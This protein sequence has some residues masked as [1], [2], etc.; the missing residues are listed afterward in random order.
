[1]CDLKDVISLKTKTEKKLRYF[2]RMFD[3]RGVSA[4]LP[5][6]GPYVWEQHACLRMFVQIKF[7]FY[8]KNVGKSSF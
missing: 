2:I 7:R 3:I 4:D 6:P 8:L 5:P 1:M